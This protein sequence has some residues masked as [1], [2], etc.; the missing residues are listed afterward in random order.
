MLTAESVARAVYSLAHEGGDS[1]SVVD[2]T[3][4]YLKKKGA[5]ALLPKVVLH[6]S[7]IASHVHAGERIVVAKN[8]NTKDVRDAAQHFGLS[9]DVPLVEDDS[10]IGGYVLAKKG[11]QIDASYKRALLTIYRSIVSG[12]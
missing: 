12:S 11:E 10:L 8:A 2:S 5:L 4:A 7:R 6:L 9:K 3:V 1:H